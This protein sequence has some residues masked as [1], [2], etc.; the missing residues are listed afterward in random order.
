[1]SMSNGPP[2]NESPRIVHTIL[3]PVGAKRFIEPLVAAQRAEGWDAELWIHPAYGARPNFTVPHRF[4]PLQ[5]TGNPISTAINVDGLRRALG[6]VRPHVVHAHQTRSAL[7]PL[8][9][10]RLEKIPRRIYHNHG[11]PYL[12]YNG[13]VRWI[14]RSIERANGALANRHLFVSRS[15]LAEA[16]RD[17]LADPEKACVIADGSIA[18]IDPSAFPVDSLA[19]DARERARTAF[20]L[21]NRFVLGYVGRPVRRKGFH[22]LLDAW[23]R[24]QLGSRG[25]LLI[26]GCTPEE[27]RIAAAADVAGVRALGHL[28]DMIPFYAACDAVALPSMHEGFSYALLEAAAAERAVIG[29]DIPGVRCAL[30][31]GKTGLLV[32]VGDADA[33]CQAI[34]RLAN[35]PILRNVFGRAG[36]VRAQS[37]F[38]RD[39][40]TRAMIRYYRERV[41]T[42]PLYRSRE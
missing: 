14:L 19:A 7:L 2:S 29:S 38:S 3:H 39:R 27:T 10:A 12:G 4:I 33:L 28:D 31:A 11:M 40:V 26:A 13:P 15:V 16:V 1:M 21:E 41:L 23:R 5:I 24:T 17:G 36:R 20:G 8:L 30:I 22:L 32:P 6:E 25:V 35:D 42:G 34:L 18:G 37:V 9:A